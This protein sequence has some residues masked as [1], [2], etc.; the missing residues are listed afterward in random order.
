V[1]FEICAPFGELGPPLLGNASRH[2]ARGPSLR[3]N[4][5][6]AA[7]DELRGRRPADN[8]GCPLR[9]LA[10]TSTE[11]S[12]E[13]ADIIAARE[14]GEDEPTSGAFKLLPNV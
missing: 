4:A 5:S 6:C 9:T 14:R 1:T 7:L 2:S 13:R 11:R 3:T 12:K 10:L 8:T